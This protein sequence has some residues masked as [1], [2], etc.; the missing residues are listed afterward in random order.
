ML[1]N[2]EK[3]KNSIFFILSMQYNTS[4]SE[5]EYYWLTSIIKLS[6]LFSVQVILDK[7]KKVM[8]CYISSPAPYNRNTYLTLI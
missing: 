2:Y 1:R 8:K 3:C 6:Q 7:K 4:T 5:I